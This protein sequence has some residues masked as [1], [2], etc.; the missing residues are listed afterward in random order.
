MKSYFM[1]YRICVTHTYNFYHTIRVYFVQCVTLLCILIQDLQ[2]PQ[3]QLRSKMA[4]KCSCLSK[5]FFWRN[6]D[7][8]YISFDLRTN[9]KNYMEN[10]IYYNK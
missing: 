6:E 5:Y 4:I 10:D 2:L 7:K 3:G 1:V 8:R 9:I